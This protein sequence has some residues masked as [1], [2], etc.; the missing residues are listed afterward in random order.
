MVLILKDSFD[1][2]KNTLFAYKNDRE[3]FTL[4]VIFYCFLVSFLLGVIFS[5]LI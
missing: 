4:S 1:L 3:C 2:K 5:S